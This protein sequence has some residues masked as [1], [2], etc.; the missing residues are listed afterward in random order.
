[1]SNI[2]RWSAPLSSGAPPAQPD[3]GA[4]GARE[5]Q[6]QLLIDATEDYAIYL[7]SPRGEVLT[8]NAGAQRAK[9]Y[10]AEEIVGRH[11]SAFYTAA[12][13]DADHPAEVL[14]L[15]AEHGSYRERGCGSGRT[16]PASGRTSP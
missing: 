9:Q 14:R 4:Y 6:L 3:A 13:L 1:M 7:L 11:F 15:A 2:S 12:D 5:Q 16:A 10:T 8:W